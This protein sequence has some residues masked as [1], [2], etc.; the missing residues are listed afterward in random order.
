M[1]N[2]HCHIAIQLGTAGVPVFM[3]DPDNF[4]RS[5]TGFRSLGFLKE[6]EVNF[7]IKPVRDSEGKSSIMD[8][9]NQDPGLDLY[10]LY[11][12]EGVSL[13]AV[14]SMRLL[15]S[16][17]NLTYLQGRRILLHLRQSRRRQLHPQLSSPSS[18]STTITSRS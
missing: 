6:L 13:G 17:R 1:G 18:S 4:G 8:L 2:R 11:V 9:Y 12:W 15:M 5:W 16:I 3:D 14:M 7:M 10:I